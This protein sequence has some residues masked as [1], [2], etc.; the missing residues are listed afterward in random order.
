MPDVH[1]DAVEARLDSQARRPGVVIRDAGDPGRIDG[2]QAAAHRREATRGR[3]CRGAIGAGVGHRPGMAD[4]RRH[5]G[6]LGVYGIGQAA[7]SGQ[8]RVV[9]QQ[10][11]AVGAPFG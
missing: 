1:L 5:G 3:Q 2:A 7:Q 11:M 8:R 4:L 10:T 6:T 9:Q